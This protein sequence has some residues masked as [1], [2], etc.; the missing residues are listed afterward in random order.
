MVWSV[1]HVKHVSVGQKTSEVVNIGVPRVIRDE[2]KQN[3]ESIF[4]TVSL[5]TYSRN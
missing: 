4:Y 2:L 5:K 3:R 1:I